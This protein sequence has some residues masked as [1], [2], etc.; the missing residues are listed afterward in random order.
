MNFEEYRRH[1]GL[2][3]AA[4]VARG[5]VTATELLEIAIARV[6]AVN[7]RLNGLIHPL[8]DAARRRAA[9]ALGGPF[10]GVPM[11]AKDLFQEMAGAPHHKGCAGLRRAGVLAEQDSE[12]VRRWQAAGLVIFGRTNTPEFGAK[13]ITEPLAWGP[14]RNPWDTDRTPGGSSG[15][16]AALVAAGVVPFAGAND[17][18]GSI[19]I[20]AACCG[21]FG[22]KPGRGRTPWGPE[23]T[24]AMHGMAINHVVTRSV[25]DSAALLDAVAGNEPGAL[26][27]IAPPERA[28]SEDVGRDPGR[29]RVAFSTRSPIGTPVDPEAI[30]AVEA[31]ARLLESLG[32]DVV[33]AEPQLDMEQM[34]MDWLKMWFAHCAATVDEVRAKTGCGDEGFEPDTLVMAAFGRQIRANEYVEVYQRGQHCMRQLAAFL[35]NHDL[36]LTPTLAMPPARIGALN[37]PAWQQQVSKITMKLGASGLVLR[38]GMVETMA[39]ENLKYTPFTQLANVTGVPAMSVPLHWCANG[40]PLGVQFVGNH[41]DEGKLLRLAAQLEQAQPWFDRVPAEVN[42]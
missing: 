38:S 17:G 14:A 7:P 18:G 22:L 3:L 33:E 5:E 21:L 11:L 37:T 12:L 1:D 23:F 40:L 8:F 34:T 27:N 6:E 39:K 28:F 35:G 13:G 9:G 19:R 4:L 32:H 15:G 2:A 26:Y 30:A 29:L 41:G 36:W 16:S 10:A 24:E 31:T 20:P 42:A 25:R